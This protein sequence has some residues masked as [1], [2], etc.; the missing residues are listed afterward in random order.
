MQN[1][2]CNTTMILSSPTFRAPAGNVHVSDVWLMVALPWLEPRNTP[3]RK[4]EY[5]NAKPP[6]TERLIAVSYPVALKWPRKI[7]YPP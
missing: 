6:C 7:R 4:A 2:P 1:L 5:P 3:F